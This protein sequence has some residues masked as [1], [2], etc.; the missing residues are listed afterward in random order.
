MY[1]ISEA[2]TLILTL[3]L[4]IL[5]TLAL[6]LRLSQ[7]NTGDTFKY[8]WHIDDYLCV[9]AMILLYG[10]SAIICW[11]ASEGAVGSHSSPE[12]V[13]NWYT[14]AGPAWIVLAKT[15]WVVFFLQPLQLGL[16][17]LA[18]LFLYRRFFGSYKAFNVAN[19]TLIAIVAGWTVAFF[20]GLLFDCGTSFSSNWGSLGEIAEKCPFGFM[21]TVIYTILDACLDLFVLLLPIPWIFQLNLSFSNKISITCCFMLGSIA[22]AAAFVRMAVFIQT[23]IPSEAM[24]RTTVMGLPTYDVLGI[25]SAEVFWTMI[26]CTVALIAVCLPAI[27]KAVARSTVGRALG[28]ATL[29]RVLRSM[30]SSKGT[31][32]DDSAVSND[33]YRPSSECGKIDFVHVVETEKAVV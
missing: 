12:D 32:K 2:S 23:G 22:T 16:I 6:G 9:A 4:T 28:L 31:R 26:E 3:V 25:V 5:A 1:A 19:W 11:G 30:G 14:T 18:I 29:S 7:G 15:F 13:E 20:F 17:R 10:S 33:N 21:P 8:R 27:R 24:N